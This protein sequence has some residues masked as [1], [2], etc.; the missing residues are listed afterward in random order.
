MRQLGHEQ[1]EQKAV[2]DNAV[3]FQ[4]A[5]DEAQRLA[6][7]ARRIV[8]E[9]KQKAEKHSKQTRAPA[10]RKQAE[11]NNVLRLLEG[12]DALQEYWLNE[13]TEASVSQ[14]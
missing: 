11:V 14:A 3:K 5:V 8:N 7:E 6:N 1:V 10:E 9:A 12:T 2:E 13:W 4:K